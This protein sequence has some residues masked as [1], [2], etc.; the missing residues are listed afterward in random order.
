MSRVRRF[1]AEWLPALLIL[2]LGLVGWELA[3]Q[4]FGIQKFLLP[5]PK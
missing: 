1:V 5:K 3:V 4:A 2:V